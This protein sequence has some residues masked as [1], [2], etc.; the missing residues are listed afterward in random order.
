MNWIVFSMD[1]VKIKTLLPSTYGRLHLQ[2]D[3]LDQ[4]TCG[5]CKAIQFVSKGIYL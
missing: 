2:L 3:S 5:F 1:T 4:S